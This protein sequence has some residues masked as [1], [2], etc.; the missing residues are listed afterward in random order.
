MDASVKRCK[1]GVSYGPPFDSCPVC[2]PAVKTAAPEAPTPK[3]S[4][5]KRHLLYVNRAAVSKLIR[6]N[7][8]RAGE[9]FMIHLDEWLHRKII[10]ACKTRNGGKITLDVTMAGHVGIK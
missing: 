6:E 2:K 7:D 1:C 8:R 10:Q 9:D 5:A 4:T 3:K